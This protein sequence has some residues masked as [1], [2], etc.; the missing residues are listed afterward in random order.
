M[1][2]TIVAI[3]VASL[4]VSMASPVFAESNNGNNLPSIP[5]MPSIESVSPQSE[6]NAS[7]TIATDN[8]T[9]LK[10]RGKALIKQ[11]VRALNRLE[12]KIKKSKL[13]EADKTALGAEI[14]ANVS[15]LKTL[16]DKIAADTDLA[17]L[18][19]DVESIF[20]AYRVYAVFLPKINGIMT[21][22]AL[23]QHANLMSTSTVAS[24]DGKIAELKTAGKDV[25][26][27]ERLMAGAKAKIAAGLSKAQ[28]A[29]T[30]FAG[31]KPADY[32]ATAAVIKTNAQLLKD[33]RAALKAAKKN[34]LKVRIWLKGMNTR[35]KLEAQ[36]KKLQEKF[37]AAKKKAEEKFE[38]KKQK[39]EKK[40]RKKEQ[41]GSATGTED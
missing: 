15:G 27:A 16:S 25:A 21:S 31:L 22:L 23:Q 32:P 36:K 17:V 11:R 18:K 7:S 26:E 30:G 38:T 34:L 35:Q 40:D 29:Q 33:S 20:T 13:A 1:K 37:E 19:A 6:G 5:S 28:S 9:A 10:A 12:Q 4:V 2:K 8:M 14:A 3:V 41:K 24:Y 39:L